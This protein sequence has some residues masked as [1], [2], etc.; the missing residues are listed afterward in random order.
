MPD[1]LYFVYRLL[2]SDTIP[3]SLI[4]HRAVCSVISSSWGTCTPCFQEEGVELSTK[5]SSKGLRYSALG[6]MRF[7][8]DVIAVAV[9]G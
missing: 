8:R 4:V 6:V 1:I 5:I 9:V 2:K 3:P 7:A